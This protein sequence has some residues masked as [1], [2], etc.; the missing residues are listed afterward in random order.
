MSPTA[1]PEPVDSA[2]EF[3]DEDPELAAIDDGHINAAYYEFWG[4]PKHRVFTVLKW[5]AFAG[6]IAW[7]VFWLGI[8][9]DW[10]IDLGIL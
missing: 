4:R 7:D 2:P 10:W 3:R 8:L 6:F 1:S 5:L 9:F